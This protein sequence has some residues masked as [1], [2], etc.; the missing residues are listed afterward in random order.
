MLNSNLDIKNDQK[1]TFK[2]VLRKSCVVQ[3]FV[4]I[5][6]FAICGLTIKICEITICKLAH[7]KNV[8]I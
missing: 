1:A 3:N 6:G 7:L 5:C 2:I 4:E 8:R